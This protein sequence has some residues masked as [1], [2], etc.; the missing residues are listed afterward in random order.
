MHNSGRLIQLLYGHCLF[1]Q[2]GFVIN[3]CSAML[4]TLGSVPYSVKVKYAQCLL[5]SLWC[6]HGS[7]NI[8]KI[9]WL[10]ERSWKVKSLWHY[11]EI[12][13]SIMNNLGG[14]T[15]TI[16]ESHKVHN[17]RL[18]MHVWNWNQWSYIQYPLA[19]WQLLKCSAQLPFAAWFSL[20]WI[21]SPLWTFN[22]ICTRVSSSLL[23]Q[24][25]NKIQ[26]LLNR[27]LI[28]HRGGSSKSLF[29]P[30]LIPRSHSLTRC[31][32]YKNWSA[33]ESDDLLT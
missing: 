22:A 3:W 15:A 29:S 33:A 23:F 21:L 6:F 9:W 14:G 1:D 27:S 11:P 8:L 10:S 25:L 20:F 31:K 18:V 28:T 12:F 24:A 32:K 4:L 19:S 13:P 17:K 5:I 30:E 26:Q 7:L 16:S 2:M